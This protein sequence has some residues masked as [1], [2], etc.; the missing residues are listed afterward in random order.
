MNVEVLVRWGTQA[1]AF[2]DTPSPQ[3]PGGCEGTQRE[4]NLGWLDRFRPQVQLWGE[5]LQL[6]E[7]TEHVVRTQGLERG[8]PEQ[9]RK[10]LAPLV[11]SPRAARMRAH[12]LA[13]VTEEALKAHPRERL[14]GSSEVIESGLGKFNRLEAPQGKSGF[15]GLLLT[16]GAM[17][18]HTT[19]E[20]IHQALETVPTKRVLEWC[21]NTL[22]D[23]LQAQRR[24]AFAVRSQTEQKCDQE[25]EAA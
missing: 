22:G 24:K 18:A 3:R 19:H 20:V 15:T 12:L 21:Q 2:L 4:E 9:L 8:S 10:L 13:F 5:V 16:I 7:V 1:L 17:V 6:V 25:L 11:L 14:L 23:S